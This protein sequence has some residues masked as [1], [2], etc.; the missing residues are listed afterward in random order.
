M[1]FFLIFILTLSYCQFNSALGTLVKKELIPAIAY[2]HLGYPLRVS[3]FFP[4][5]FLQSFCINPELNLSDLILTDT[6]F[7]LHLPVQVSVALFVSFLISSDWN[8]IVILPRDMIGSVRLT[9][10]PLSLGPLISWTLLTTYP[11]TQNFLLCPQQMEPRNQQVT[12][13]TGWCFPQKNPFL[14]MFCDF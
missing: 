7:W 3:L 2:L 13:G 11:S 4:T 5:A 9:A 8:T 6:F 14:D 1:V 10:R 12:V